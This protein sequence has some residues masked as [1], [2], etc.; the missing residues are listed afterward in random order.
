[1]V[2]RRNTSLRSCQHAS[3]GPK[4]KH[5]P[6]PFVGCRVKGARAVGET[7]T[8]QVVSRRNTSLRKSTKEK[9]GPPQ[10]VGYKVTGVGAVVK[11]G[12]RKWLVGG[13]RASA[14]VQTGGFRCLIY[15]EWFKVGIRATV[16]KPL[17]VQRRNTSLLNL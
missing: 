12:L 2:S 3:S 1:L 6:P 8:P 17:Q 4:E 7:R 11:L 9:H 16:N 5:G 15:G 10:F 13:T 14:K